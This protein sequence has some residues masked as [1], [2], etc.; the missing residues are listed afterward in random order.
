MDVEN[1]LYS[2]YWEDFGQFWE[3]LFVNQRLEK[4]SK[5]VLLAEGSALQ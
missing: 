1:H 2:E 4:C 3:E 5:Y